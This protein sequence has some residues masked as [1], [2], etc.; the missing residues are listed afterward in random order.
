MRQVL[1]DQGLKIGLWHEVDGAEACRTGGGASRI[2]AAVDAIA[3]FPEKDKAVVVL[4]ECADYRQV[5]TAIV[6]VIVVVVGT[7]VDHY[8][9]VEI[10][11]LVYT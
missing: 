3:A 11:F 5:V 9:R 8:G 6:L 1:V 10:V 2:R 4:G 7:C